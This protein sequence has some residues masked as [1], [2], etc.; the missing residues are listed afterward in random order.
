LSE[1]LTFICVP[2]RTYSR[3]EVRAWVAE[4]RAAG[5]VP[6][7]PVEVLVKHPLREGDGSCRWCGQGPD[8]TL[9]VA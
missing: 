2:E 5:R 4:L 6:D 1:S 3:M 7:G 8:E 9:Q